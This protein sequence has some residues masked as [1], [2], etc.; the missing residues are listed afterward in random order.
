MSPGALASDGGIVRGILPIRRD[1]P[2][3]HRQICSSAA[4]ISFG[5]LNDPNCLGEV[6]AVADSE[7]P[8]PKPESL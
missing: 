5:A 6:L 2:L 1:T 8:N 7:K 3:Q 4:A